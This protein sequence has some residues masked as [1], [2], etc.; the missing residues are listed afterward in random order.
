MHLRVSMSIPLTNES[1]R[2]RLNRL[3]SWS[4]VKQSVIWFVRN[5]PQTSHLCRST[6]CQRRRLRIWHLQFVLKYLKYSS[7]SSLLGQR[8]S[9]SYLFA[10]TV[11]SIHQSSSCTSM[12]SQCWANRD[13]AWVFQLFQLLC[14]VQIF[15]YSLH[16]SRDSQSL[17]YC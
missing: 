14:F 7:H 17:S 10:W 16:L 9:E 4:R 6:L 15:Q 13:E 8:Q 12:M 2:T 1:L 5:L 3:H 11:S